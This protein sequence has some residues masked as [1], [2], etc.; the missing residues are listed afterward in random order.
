MRPCSTF[1]CQFFLRNSTLITNILQQIAKIFSKLSAGKF[2]YL[3]YLL[4]L[5]T[6]KSTVPQLSWQSKGLKILVSPVRFLVAPRK[7]DEKSRPS[8]FVAAGWHLLVFIQLIVNRVGS[9]LAAT[10]RAMVS[11]PRN[12]GRTK[13][14]PYS[15]VIQVNICVASSGYLTH[16][17]MPN[18]LLTL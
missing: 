14:R 17:Q 12:P 3:K 9:R 6:R 15:V 13:A 10:Y 5:C 1:L 2:V 8:F 11:S 16:R 18:N 4:Y 7:T